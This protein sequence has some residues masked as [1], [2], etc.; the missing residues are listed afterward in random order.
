MLN[1]HKKMCFITTIEGTMN[2][3]I[4]PV[5]E[6]FVKEGYDVTLVCSMSD[7]FN[8]MNSKKFT[9]INIP[10]RR[11]ISLMDIL[12]VPFKFLRLF[13]K[14]KF[15]YVQYATTNA[16]FYAG[17]PAKLCGVKTRV[18]CQWGL[19]YVGYSGFKRQVFKL[20]ETILCLTATHVT[21]ASKKNLEYAVKDHIMPASKA[22]VIGDGGTIG[23]D[24]SIFDVTKREAFRNQVFSEYPQLKGK[25]V[26]GYV[27]R[28]ESDKGIVELLNAFLSLNDDNSA[29]LLVGAFD[30]LRCK[31]DPNLLKQ[32]I[33]TGNVIFHGFSREVPK[34]MS[35]IDILVHPTYREGFSM[36]I[37]QAMAMKC[38]IIT[39]DVPGPS[40]VI[41]D[42]ISGILVK[43]HSI[44]DLA[45]AMSLIA[46]DTELR[47]RLSL[48]ALQRVRE[49]FNRQRML[50]LTYQDRLRMMND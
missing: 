10:M 17:I 45:T 47:N 28:I 13:R 9:C 1:N 15:D 26:Y 16:S 2:S 27:G 12:M 19:L 6:R 20:I 46:S 49:K 48:S 30:H 8:K 37:Q 21:V 41:E 50:E 38:T 7:E 18:Y 43:D 40:E 29:L 35:A 23:V 3:F 24:F 5:M 36:V 33:S 22:S 32:A 11:G 39:T 31:I 44:D 42:G 4:I 14:E 25:L 34:Y